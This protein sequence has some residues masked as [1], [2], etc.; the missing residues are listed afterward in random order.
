MQSKVQVGSGGQTVCFDYFWAC[1]HRSILSRL[2]SN[3]SI[4]LRFAYVCVD[5]KAVHVATKESK[6]TD[7]RLEFEGFVKQIQAAQQMVALR[8]S[9]IQTSQT[10]W[11]FAYFF[12]F[13]FCFTDILR[14]Y[15]QQNKLQ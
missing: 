11:M 15:D 8:C 6:L 14:A 13:C 10:C 4:P 3:V 2:V 7:L 5:C 12:P 1:I 9:N